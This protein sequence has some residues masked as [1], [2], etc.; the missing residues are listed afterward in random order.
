MADAPGTNHWPTAP[1][2]ATVNWMGW[3]ADESGLPMSIVI[4][5]PTA[6]PTRPMRAF[7]PT[8]SETVADH[9]QRDGERR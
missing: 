9:R 3:A 8:I 4:T 1:H 5:A 2:G 6:M 7:I